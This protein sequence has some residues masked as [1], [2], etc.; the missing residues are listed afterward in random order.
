[1]MNL[2]K[3]KSITKR[4]AIQYI[5][6]IATIFVTPLLLMKL[7]N[8]PLPNIIYL[9]WSSINKTDIVPNWVADFPK[10]TYWH[11]F[12][13]I[14]TISFFVNKTTFNLYPSKD[15][16]SHKYP[17]AYMICCSLFY[18]LVYLVYAMFLTNIVWNKWLVTDFSGL[19]TL[20][21]I[22]TYQFTVVWLFVHLLFSGITIKVISDDDVEEMKKLKE[23][24]S[25]NTLE[26]ILKQMNDD[27]N[28]EEDSE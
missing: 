6:A 8:G 25:K 12:F 24:E 7:W 15:S 28:K 5:I 4:T 21:C 13:Y 22:T 1:M 9:V 20:P 16:D 23:L 2:V 14:S 17:I 26:N 27:V 18:I 19:V 10:I 11:W 3:I